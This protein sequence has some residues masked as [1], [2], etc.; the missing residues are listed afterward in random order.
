MSC[1]V[2]LWAWAPAPR[3]PSAVCAPGWTVTRFEPRERNWVCTCTDAPLPTETIAMTDATP[4]MTPSIVSAERSLLTMI[5]WSADRSES[6]SLTG[7]PPRGCAGRP[8]RSARPSGARPLP[9][10]TVHER[11][12]DVLERIQPWQEI[13]GLEDES[14]VPVA[15]CRQPVV[16][17]RPDLL[18]GEDIRAAVG[19]VEAPEDVHHRRLPGS[20]GPHERDELAFP[21]VEIGAAEGVDDVVLPHAVGLRDPTK[22]EDRLVHRTT[23]PPPPPPGPNP[24]WPEVAARGC[25]STTTSPSSSPVRTSVTVSLLIPNVASASTVC[26]SFITCT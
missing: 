9:A 2:R 15:Q 24:G 13:E 4:M 25:G 7:P 8:S 11:Q 19:H 21:H 12:L 23:G 17:Q 16:A 10:A 1:R 22:L 18:A 5:D 6:R 20:R 3:R 14:D 26:P